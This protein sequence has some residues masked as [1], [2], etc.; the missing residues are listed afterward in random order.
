MRH[1]RSRPR[2][3]VWWSLCAALLMCRAW[4]NAGAVQE[5]ARTAR[6]A[7][8]ETL[9]PWLT[10]SQIDRFLAE[11][12]DQNIS[13]ILVWADAEQAYALTQADLDYLRKVAQKAHAL[14]PP[15]RVIVYLAPL[16]QIS[17]NVDMDKNGQVDP[18]KHSIYSDHPGWAQ[19][20][21]DGRP[22][23][24]YG[25]IA[26]WVG[27]HDED[28]WV[29]PNNPEWRAKEIAAFEKVGATGIDGVW[30]DR[31]E[32]MS[33]LG[34]PK[35]RDEWACHCINCRNLFRQEK[36]AEIPS[37][38]D[39]SNAV[40]RNWIDW[41]FQ[42]MGKFISDCRAAARRKNASFVIFN[43]FYDRADWY[44]TEAGFS[45]VRTRSYN[46]GVAHEW[47]VREPPNKY[48]YFDWK[49]DLVTYRSYRGF[50][51][52]RP[53]WV[54]AYSQSVENSKTL[55]STELQAGCNFYEVKYYEMVPSVDKSFRSKI[56]AW[57]R[58][59]EDGY[60]GE[61]LE[62]LAKVA[63][64]YSEPSIH[65]IDAPS[66]G[67]DDVYEELQGLGILL[68]EMHV[69]Y[70]VIGPAQL[71]SLSGY[72]AVVLPNAASMSPSEIA[73]FTAFVNDGGKL[74]STAETSLYDE[75]GQRRTNYGLSEVF[76]TTYPAGGI[77]VN[78]YGSGLSVFAPRRF[79]QEYFAAVKPGS[80]N[81]IAS[82]E[83]KIRADFTTG[84]WS[85]IGVSP[86]V[87]ISGHEWLAAD[88]YYNG[89]QMIVR[90]TNYK[91]IKGPSEKPAP[92]SGVPMDIRLPAGFS[93]RSA[94]T[95][96]L[97]EGAK[98]LTFSLP[99]AGIA[100]VTIS[101]KNHLLI[102]IE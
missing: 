78:S 79:G 30:W 74:V 19:V 6:L 59:N 89:S 97:L 70:V 85:T 58:E 87:A 93:P 71:A 10:D 82:K 56:F 45:S 35:W 34:T 3:F 51:Q 69:N 47:S 13:T 27:P 4:A 64:Y 72:D 102:V 52:E 11:H 81:T 57:I 63:L 68:G 95:T 86:V 42:K 36:G 60:Y 1:D 41:R 38:V 22:A 98:P 55:S 88:S 96:E 9:G 14:S 75:G 37:V 83:K 24:F 73:A 91:N 28:A 5:W 62:P 84:V 39:F 43:E 99:S 80:P 44:T 26:F 54:L 53:S 15:M 20:G 77:V 7:G 66:R 48:K 31:P 25:A 17:E 61:G 92:D 32:F 100:R 16:E 12:H 2:A 67:N 21:I 18:G 49:S 90:V 46:D 23:V 29:C 40:W 76:G 33:D 50:D 65:W 8:S 101:V 94:T